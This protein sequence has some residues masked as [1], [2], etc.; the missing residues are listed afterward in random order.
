[1]LESGEQAIVVALM[2]ADARLIKDVQ[3]ADQACADLGSQANP[4]RLTAAEGAALA[5]KGE[6]SEADVL[7]ECEPGADFFDDF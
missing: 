1:M 4:L 2:E 7:E 5:I 6:I 3:Y